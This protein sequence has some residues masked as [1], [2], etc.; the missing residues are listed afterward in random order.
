MDWRARRATARRVISVAPSAAHDVRRAGSGGRNTGSVRRPRDRRDDGRILPIKTAR[1]RQDIHRRA[2]DRRSRRCRKRVGVTATSHKVVLHLLEEAV[3]VAEKSGSPIVAVHKGKDDLASPH[4]IRH[5]QEGQQEGAGPLGRRRRRLGR[6][7]LVLVRRRCDGRTRRSLRRRSRADVARQRARRF[8]GGEDG[9]AVGRSAPIGA[10]FEGQSSRRFRALGARSHPHGR[11]TI[12]ETQGLFLAETWRLHPD[13]CKFTSEMFYEAAS[14]HA[15]G[16]NNKSHDPRPIERRRPALS[17]C[18]AYRQSEFVRRGSGGD[19]CARHRDA[20]DAPTWIDRDGKEHKLTLD[21]ILIVAPYNAQVF[22]LKHAL[23]NARIGTVDK[24]Q[25][26]EAPIVIYS[27][28]SS[29]SGD[30]RAAWNSSTAS[31]A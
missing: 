27:M 22:A 1:R 29:S 23:P 17:A 18:G 26:Q 7:G 24:F 31:T 30:A 15:L 25:G 3:K 19:P 28:T 8:T 4:R 14:S 21:D 10:T 6:H 5:R 20:A 9:R 16:W 2:H 13:I 11:T 12:G